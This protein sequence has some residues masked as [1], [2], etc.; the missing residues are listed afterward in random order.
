MD[1]LLFPLIVLRPVMVVWSRFCKSL[2]LSRHLKPE[3]YSSLC[4]PTVQFITT[5]FAAERPLLTG[6][7]GF[8]LTLGDPENF[9]LVNLIAS[10]KKILQQ[11]PLSDPKLNIDAVQFTN[12]KNTR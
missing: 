6:V 1:K 4:S 11:S 9:V 12:T 8:G 5:L 10:C 7:E 2:A 3:E